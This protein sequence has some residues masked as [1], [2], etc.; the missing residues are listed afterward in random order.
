MNN[1]TSMLVNAPHHYYRCKKI[2]WSAILVGA[3]VGVG[4]NFLLNLFCVAI[5]L[6]VITTNQD[7]VTALAV[8]GFIGLLI[9]VI[10]A[11]FV[12][13][14]VSGYLG[15]AFCPKRNL[16]VLY[17]FT[18]WSVALIFI[19]VLATHMTQFVT[20]YTNFLYNQTPA[21]N[22]VNNDISP[23]VTAT[24]QTTPAQVTVNAQ[25]AVNTVGYSAF[26]VFV[27]F[28]VGAFS[29]SLGGHF[30][31]GRKCKE[32]DMQCNNDSLRKNDQLRGNDNNH[33]I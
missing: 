13:G 27:L 7:G 22:M 29:A 32:D 20:S 3:V 17:G 12:A 33:R 10:V 28:F 9:S 26:L 11:M 25:K 4:L 1:D 8:G 5:G 31:M 6:S 30:G 21:V 16:G 15:R 14:M 23:A 18:A 24:T 2:S 19:V